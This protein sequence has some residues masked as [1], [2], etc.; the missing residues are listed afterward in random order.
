[1][2]AYAFVE[3]NGKGLRQGI[4]KLEEIRVNDLPYMATSI[5]NK[6]FNIE[7][8]DALE[9]VNMIDAAEMVCRSALMREES[10]GLHQR[11]DHPNVDP[12]WLKHILIE[13]RGD[14]IMMSTEPVDFSVIK[15]DEVA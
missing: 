8:L 3:R 4:E 15:P 13:K 6:V 1:M 9:A 12:E 7:W 14:E 11:S 2:S 10:R 5:K